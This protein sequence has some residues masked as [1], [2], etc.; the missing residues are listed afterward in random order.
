MATV[1]TNLLSAIPFIGKDLVPFIWGGFNLFEGPYY[2]D[3]ILKILLDAEISLRFKQIMYYL[4]LIFIVKIIMTWGQSAVVKFNNFATQRLNAENLL[5]TNKYIKNN[6]GFYNDYIYAY[7]VGLIE[8]DGWINISKKGKYLTYEVGI[9]LNIR[10]IKLLYKIKDILGIGIIKTRKRITSTG[11][12]IELATYSIRNKKHLIE[13]I[14]PIFDKYPM[15]TLKHY[16]YLNFRY[17]LLNNTIYYKNYNKYIRDNKPIYTINE[18][19]NKDY[20]SAWLIGFIEAEGSF[21]TYKISKDNS[22][23][24]YFEISQTKD[25]IIINAIKS[26]LNISNLI[27]ID[28][29]NNYKLKVSSIKGITNIINFMDKTPIKLLGYKKIQYLLFLKSIRQ[30]PK[31]SNNINIPNIY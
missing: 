20:F 29:T 31:Y 16:D 12:E 18:I 6:H 22:T 17:N 24:A 8:G 14:I 26:Y 11:I 25:T 28:K 9:E 15:L 2:S 30:I 21:G 7:L 23:I 3:I 13:V 5:K 4:I 1:I 10:D 19:L 27:T